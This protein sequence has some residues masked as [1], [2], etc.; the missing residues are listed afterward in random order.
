MKKRWDHL[1]ICNDGN[2]A[3]TTYINGAL[4]HTPKITFEI[5]LR[6][7]S[8]KEMEA[9]WHKWQ[10]SMGIHRSTWTQDVE[11]FN[12]DDGTRTKV[13]HT[14]CRYCHKDLKDHWEQRFEFVENAHI[15][16][17]YASTGWVITEPQWPMPIKSPRGEY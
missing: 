12:N 3:E 10:C 6:L 16:E 5:F 13:W 2:G 11:T 4:R 9:R 8:I 14:E 1:V 17:G 15:T 7:V